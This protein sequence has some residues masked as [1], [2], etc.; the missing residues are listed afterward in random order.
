MT[1]IAD[2]MTI[3]AA[4][5]VASHV[6]KFAVPPNAAR[7]DLESGFEISCREAADRVDALAALHRA[8]GYGRDRQDREA[9]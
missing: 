1:D 4:S 7:G 5:A 8:A 3:G 6:D 2:G 9:G